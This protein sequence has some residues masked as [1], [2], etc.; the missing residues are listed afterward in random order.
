MTYFIYE[1][2]EHNAHLS[3]DIQFDKFRLTANAD[4]TSNLFLPRNDEFEALLYTEARLPPN[5]HSN[6][7]CKSTMH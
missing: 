5:A 6:G 3:L 7:S 4:L 2:C 1:T